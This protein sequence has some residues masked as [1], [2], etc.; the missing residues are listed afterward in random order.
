MSDDGRDAPIAIAAPV[1]IV[2]RLN[3]LLERG[4][5]IPRLQGLML[6]IEGAACQ[7]SDLQQTRQRIAALARAR[8]ALFASRC[9]LRLS[10]GFELF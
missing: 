5:T 10:Q 4:V 6:V 8:F 3:A 1:N 7:A 9:M 2:D